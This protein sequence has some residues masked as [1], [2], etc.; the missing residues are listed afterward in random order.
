MALPPS[1]EPAPI[2]LATRRAVLASL[3][4]VV[5]CV[6]GVWATESVLGQLA[7]SDAVAYPLLMAWFGTLA[8]ALWQRPARLLAVQRLAS[9]GLGLYFIGSVALLTLGPVEPG[10]YTLSTLGHWLMAAHLMLFITWPPRRALLLSTLL[11]L[12]V[13][14]PGAWLSWRGT[15][16]PQWQATLWPLLV[17]GFFAQV[18]VVATLYG[19]ARQLQKLSLLVPAGDA[20]RTQPLTVD[21]VLALRLRD[22]ESARDAAEAASQAKSRFLAVMSHEL[23]T[24]L[25]GVLGA[26]ELLQRET[27]V[28]P[29]QQA[30]VATVQRGG[31]HLL[32]LVEDMLD[33]SRI[34]A[35][36]LDLAQ[37]PLDLRRCLARALESVQ[38]LA[39]SKGLQLS[40]QLDAG[41]PAWVRGDALR[42]S[43][44]LINLLGN[45]VKFTDRGE[46]QLRAWHEAARGVLVEVRDSGI[47]IAAADRERIFESFVQADSG[48]TRRHGGTGLGLAITR[49]LVGLMGGRL[50]LDSELGR[51]TRVQLVLP[52]PSAE[53]P[54]T[55]AE[56]EAEPTATLAGMRVLLVD[57]DSVNTTI[58]SHLLELM[59]AQVHCADSGEAALQWLTHSHCDIVLMDWRM[60]GMDG[61]EATRRL[62]AGQAGAAGRTVPVLALTASA[63]DDDRAACLAAGMNDV[64]VKPVDGAT[65]LQALRRHL[66]RPS[67]AA[68]PAT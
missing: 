34:E 21:E 24:P 5:A 8:L 19:V 60:P 55:T 57:D 2:S 63:F 42:L 47:G 48:S 33:L 9:L 61:L 44:V 65:L 40:S 35:G 43:Q 45:A 4:L 11:A 10:V 56:N 66:P 36:R 18:F 38:P 23:R 46:V 1:P 12:L 6:A 41:L 49:Q 17:N 16:W 31:R 20:A 54:S 26:A 14:L 59:Q 3:V 29:E 50:A 28:T 52:L 39:D 22:L 64:L 67:T 37:Q 25:H 68:A 13:L 30:W 51:G 62:R 32:R 7:A 27:G 53:P 15:P 58:A